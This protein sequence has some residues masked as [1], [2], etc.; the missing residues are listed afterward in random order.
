MEPIVSAQLITRWENEKGR[1]LYR[2][3]YTVLRDAILAGE[4]QSGERLPASRSLAQLL[5]IS[6]NTVV[7]AFEILQGDGFLSS[8]RG[9]GIYVNEHIDSALLVAVTDP[10]DKDERTPMLPG[11]VQEWMTVRKR[12][13]RRG[14]HGAFSPGRPA[15][16]AFPFDIWA[17]LLS[18]RWRLSGPKLAMA[19]DVKGYQVFIVS[20]AQQGLDLLARV[21]WQAGDE[22]VIENPSFPGV[23]G[24]AMG[25]GV[26]VCPVGLDEEGLAV[27][28]LKE[29]GNLNSI[30]VTPSRNYPLG[31]T[32]TLARRL[33]LLHLAREKTAWVV[34]DDFDS[35]FRFDGPPLSSLQGLDCDGRV[36]YV[37]TFSRILFPALR[38]GYVVVPPK[39][40]SAFNAARSYM[41][42]HAS[43]V[44][45]AV[46]ADFMEEGYF[47]SHLRRMKKLY[48]ERRAYLMMRLEETLSDVCHIVAGDGG[49][50]ICLLFKKALDDRVVSDQVL[51]KGTVARPLSSFYRGGADKQGLVLG[52]AGFDQA[53]TDAGLQHLCDILADN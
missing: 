52:F 43:I 38:L 13:H 14:D 9:A 2:A 41:D 21:L 33:D 16:D 12:H 47:D 37:G 29:K 18:R 39:L 45:Q 22:V 32:M 53:A 8:R 26:K 19:D 23:D 34:E 46:L 28:M 31:T 24:V 48:K 10:A 36:L 17:R 20:G 49:L 5:S 4:L 11:R 27:S 6:R 50:H 3:L 30:F 1:P 35:D 40:E 15:L 7:Q 25:A 44:H 42:G 51:E